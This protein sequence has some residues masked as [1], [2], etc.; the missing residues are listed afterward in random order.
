MQGGRARRRR[1][2]VRNAVARAKAAS[3][4]GD[5]RALRQPARLAAA[6]AVPATPRRRATGARSGRPVRP[7]GVARARALTQL[8]LVPAAPLDQRPQPV[9][10]STRASNPISV[11]ARSVEPM[12][13]RHERDPSGRTGSRRRAGDASS[14]SRAR[15]STFASRCRRCRRGRRCRRASRT[16]SPRRS[17]RRRRS[18][19]PG[20]RRRTSVGS[21]RSIASSIRMITA[22]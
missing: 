22:M 2:R 12:R 7:H 19:M 17:R 9:L 4:A 1:E 13:L 10:E 20:S 18:R 8:L 11:V 16:R 6:R 14:S 15:R 3:N 21:P 5:L